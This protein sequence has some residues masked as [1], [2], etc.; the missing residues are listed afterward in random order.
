MSTPFPAIRPSSRQYQ[1]PTVPV[2]EIRSESGLVF[3]RRRGSLAVDAT[4]S[5]SFTNRPAADWTAIEEAWLASGC[6][7]DGLDLPAEVW[8]PGYAP[9]LPGLEWR[10]V[11]DKPPQRQQDKDQR[12][13]VSMTVELRAVAV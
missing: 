4:V 3:R 6:G 12:G 2:S 7:M 1:P 8:L 13:R 11:P 10:F 5:L 9:E